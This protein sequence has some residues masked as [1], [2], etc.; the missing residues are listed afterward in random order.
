M[1]EREKAASRFDILLS[2]YTV[3]AKEKL[4]FLWPEIL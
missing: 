1:I 4:E 3:I 2:G